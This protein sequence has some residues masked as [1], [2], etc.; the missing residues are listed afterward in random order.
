[1]LRNTIKISLAFTTIGL[2][3]GIAS[4]AQA[5]GLI[6]SPVS[7]TASSEFGTNFSIT[8]TINQSGLSTGFNSGVDDFDTYLASN[9]T[10]TLAAANNEWFTARDVTNATVTYDLG[11][12]FNINRLA[13]WN[14]ESS[15]IG[16]FNISV[17]TDNI[18]YFNVASNLNPFDNPLDDY[19]AEVFG[20]GASNARYVRFDISGCPQLDPGGF[21]GCGIG[22]VAFGTTV[23]TTEVPEPAS[24]AGVGVAFL[25]GTLA[26]KK[27]KLAQ[28]LQ[29]Q[30]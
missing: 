9:P 21:N 18:N 16:S 7:A 17:S 22:E 23:G 26:R 2:S 1:M 12:L 11:N 15:G 14:E 28:K 27:S 20:F 8:N 30:E 10:H 6:L 13:L 24:T 4:Q 5:V 25:L 19:P 29:N 3:L